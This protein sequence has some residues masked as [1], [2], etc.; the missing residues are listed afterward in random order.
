MQTVTVRFQP[1]RA[2]CEYYRH[3]VLV[4][5]PNQPKPTYFSFYGMCFMY[6][7]SPPNADIRFIRRDVYGQT[8]ALKIE[9]YL[10]RTHGFST[11][12]RRVRARFVFGK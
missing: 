1:H 6:Q 10:W 9:L 7:M 4:S 11:K 3:K 2:P 12:I 8:G 5:V